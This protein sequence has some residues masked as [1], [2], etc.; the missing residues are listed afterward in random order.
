MIVGAISVIDVACAKVD[1][2]TIDDGGHSIHLVTAEKRCLDARLANAVN[3]NRLDFLCCPVRPEVM[4]VG[5]SEAEWI[6]QLF[7][8]NTRLLCVSVET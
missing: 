2:T 7:S 4:I 3:V 5:D 1:W 6:R 8:N